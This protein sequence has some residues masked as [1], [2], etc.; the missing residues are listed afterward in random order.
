MFCDRILR[1]YILF[2]KVIRQSKVQHVV[3]RVHMS[4]GVYSND[5]HFG[6]ILFTVMLAAV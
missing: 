5:T 3:W 6:S 4:K 2:C 1:A